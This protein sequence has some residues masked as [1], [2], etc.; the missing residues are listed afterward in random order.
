MSP[1]V[2]PGALNSAEEFKIGQN[3]VWVNRGL[4]GV[5]R[6]PNT[7]NGI[8]TPGV[9]IT[10]VLAHARLVSYRSALYANFSQ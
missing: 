6:D 5:N 9:S 1:E 2:F 8:H 4:H 7:K 3:F 10:C